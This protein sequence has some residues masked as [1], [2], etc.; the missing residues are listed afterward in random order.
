[1]RESEQ[2]EFKKS[3][4]E[5]DEAM[6]S[7]SAILNKHKSGT[8]YFGLKNDGTPFKM[9]INDST[10]RDISRKIYESI[11][12]QIFPNITTDI[13]DEIEIIKVEFDGNDIPY[14]SKGKYYI[15]V[16]DE[17]RELSPKELKKIMIQNEYNENFEDHLTN[18]TIDDVDDNTLTQFFENAV[19]CSRLPNQEFNKDELLSKLDLIH[20]G[21]LT[22]AGRLLFSKNNPLVLKCAI[23]ATD[24]KL[25]FLDIKR[26]EGNIFELINLGM[27][28]IIENINWRVEFSDNS[29]QRMEIPEIPVKALREALVNSFAH[30]RYDV[31]VQHEIDI[32]SNRISITNPGN[33][34]NDNTPLDY[35]IKEIKSFLRNEK[36]AHILYLCN[37]VEVFGHGIKKVYHLCQEANVSIT[38]QN[39]DTDFT[40]EFSRVDRNKVTTMVNNTNIEN[41]ELLNNNEKLVLAI[42]VNNPKITIEELIIKVDKSERTIKRIL[43]SLKTK[44]LI[45]R[46]NS[47]KN[48]YWE[49]FK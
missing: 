38:Y 11:K 24:Q 22:N 43:N 49:I 7:I 42:L 37:E 46:M 2:I 15:R 33:F 30:A 4:N 31:K 5:L 14:S 18:E 39:T 13:I 6:N 3:T 17:D 27:R 25:T 1:M 32:F 19:S 21:Y 41:T 16:A 10:L 35:A 44:K 28:Y 47:S 34:A 40:F 45:K 23:F 48:G 12:P 8:L 9:N 36:I 20:D 26:F 29:I